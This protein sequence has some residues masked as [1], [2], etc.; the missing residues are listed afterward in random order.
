MPKI[1]SYRISDVATA[2]GPDCEQRIVGIRPGEK[3][4]EEMITVS[5]SF[6]CVDLGEYFA[7]LPASDAKTRERY[8][9]RNGV[10]AVPE[11]F[12]YNSGTNDEFL[13]VEELRALIARHVEPLG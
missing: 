4:H 9:A 6:N 12:C 13:T 1:P 11:G 7:V 5:D 3:I 2:I 10:Q 8:M